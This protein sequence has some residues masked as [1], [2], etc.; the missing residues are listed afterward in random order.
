MNK[1]APVPEMVALAP[2]ELDVRLREAD[3]PFVIRGLVADW[4]LVEALIRLSH[5]AR[6]RDPGEMLELA[7]LAEFASRHLHVDSLQ[8]IAT[9]INMRL[10]G[11][12]GF[13]LKLVDTFSS[14]DWEKQ[15]MLC[16]GEL[17]ERYRLHAG[18]FRQ[19]QYDG[20]LTPTGV[21]QA[22]M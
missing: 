1:L 7:F 2:D 13:V 16:G 14:S 6:Y 22:Q 19:S 11:K 8:G 9:V 15:V 17:L 12:W 3:R 21:L 10:S 20:I 4:P 5:E 18:A